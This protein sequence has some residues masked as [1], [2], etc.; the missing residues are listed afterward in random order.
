MPSHVQVHNKAPIVP[1]N[2]SRPNV[3]NIAQGFNE[4]PFV[5]NHYSMLCTSFL[6]DEDDEEEDVSESTI[7]LDPAQKLNASECQISPPSSESIESLKSKPPITCNNNNNNNRNLRRNLRRN[8][9]Q[10][11]E[12]YKNVHKNSEMFRK[13]NAYCKAMN[14]IKLV[15]KNDRKR[16]GKTTS[17]NNNYTKGQEIVAL[18]TCPIRFEIRNSWN[19]KNVTL[20]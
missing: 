9:A 2:K 18:H 7:I 14:R 19:S 4:I 3:S 11:I 5:A 12:L 10:R 20:T 1:L 6:D 17:N 15:G 16:N 8:I 13:A